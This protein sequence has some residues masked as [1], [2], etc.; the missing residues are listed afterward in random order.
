MAHCDVSLGFITTR[1]FFVLAPFVILA[2]HV[3][4]IRT[5]NV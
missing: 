5:S 4:K 3:S 2:R 1:K